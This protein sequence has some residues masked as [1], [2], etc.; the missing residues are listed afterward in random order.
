MGAF[1]LFKNLNPSLL[2]YCSKIEEPS[3]S[4]RIK[5]ERLEQAEQSLFILPDENKAWA[6]QFISQLES[7]KRV[8]VN[9]T[10]K[11]QD[12]IENEVVVL[13]TPGHTKGHVSFYIPADRTIIAND[14]LV[15]EDNKLEIANPMFTLDM[16]Q[17]IKSVE[18]IKQINPARIICYHGGIMTDNITQQLESVIRKYEKPAVHL[19]VAK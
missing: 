5:S 9:I 15:I 19:T 18:L 13:Y 12:K 10:L 7:L 2:V 17:A 16:A 14:A 6:L 11:D 8:Q 4:G 1:T 3:V